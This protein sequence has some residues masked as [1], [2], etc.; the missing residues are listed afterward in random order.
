MPKFCITCKED[1]HTYLECRKAPFATIFAGAFGLPD[2]FGDQDR[3]EKNLREIADKEDA[4]CK[5][6]S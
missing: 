3:V 4:P 2:L 6:E 5:I 1:G